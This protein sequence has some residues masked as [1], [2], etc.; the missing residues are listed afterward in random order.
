MDP[1]SLVGLLLILIG[2]FVGSILKGVQPVA[3]F[4]VPAAFLIV[5]GATL[6]AS[7]LSF[8]TEDLKNLP[9]VMKKALLPGAKPDVVGVVGQ[10][11]AFADTARR[12]GL[13]ALE[14][15]VNHTE[16]PFLRRG[17][18]MAIDGADPESVRDILETD[19]AA[20]KQRHKV[21]AQ[22]LN[23]MGV[24]AP[25]F[26]IIGAVV[27]L[28][29]TL[30]HLDDPELLGHGIAAAFIATFWGVFLANGMFLPMGK[31][32]ARLSTDEVAYRELIIEGVLA[33]QAGASPRTVE[34]LL[35]S[36]L[37]PAL[38][39]QIGDGSRPLE[40]VPDDERKSA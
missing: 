1:A 39:D 38:R 22:Y 13:L 34:D 20:M 36:F 3:F 24:F 2:I 14:E 32:V 9:K 18:Q 26:G 31:K 4:S 6:G 21:G 29:A 40:A 35:K 5:L 19:V 16:E 28:I 12:E 23:S 25:T 7:M 27:G 11:V 10:L 17:L 15:Q 37:P 8:T 33:V 30:S